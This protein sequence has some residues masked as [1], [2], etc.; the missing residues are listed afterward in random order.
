MSSDMLRW[1]LHVLSVPNGKAP[2]LAFD[3]EVRALDD[4]DSLSAAWAMLEARGSRVSRV[5]FTPIGIVAE[6]EVS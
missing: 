4:E 2:R 5:A 3:L 1:P 6:V